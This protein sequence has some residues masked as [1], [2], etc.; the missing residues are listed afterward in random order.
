MQRD[1]KMREASETAMAE[2]LLKLRGSRS[3]E[4]MAEVCDLSWRHYN[5]LEHCRSAVSAV[6]LV[7]LYAAGIDLNEWAAESLRRYEL[8]KKM[9]G[10]KSE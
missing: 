7:R 9:E 8:L 5:G 1:V 2:Y 3:Q 6:T 4:T 10:D